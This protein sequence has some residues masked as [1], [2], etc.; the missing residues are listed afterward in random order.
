MNTDLAKIEKNLHRRWQGMVERCTNP[1]YIGYKNYGGRGIMVCDR[2]RKFS[3]F[4]EDVF[5]SFVAHMEANGFRGTQMD[6]IDNEK[7]YTASNVRWV[8]P[9]QNQN[10]RRNN[11]LIH[12]FGKS[13]TSTQWAEE[14]GMRRDTIEWRIKKTGM[15]PE[16]A[17]VNRTVKRRLRDSDAISIRKEYAGGATQKR[18]GEKYGLSTTAIANI[19]NERTYITRLNSLTK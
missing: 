12:A 2:W 4:Y 7:G 9:R 17:L 19:V 8:T 14:L 15:K 6:R 18:L 16:D 5:D 13:Q 1:N 3:A 11:V 10:N